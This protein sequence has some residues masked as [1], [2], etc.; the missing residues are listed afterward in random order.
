MAAGNDYV[1]TSQIVTFAPGDTIKTVQVPINNDTVYEG[2][3]Q[4]TAQ[5]T[6]T[7]SG[8]VIFQPDAIA[9]IND[10]DGIFELNYLQV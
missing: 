7:D 4:F 6:T 5:L 9:R 8:V 1:G 10:N 3:E 2:L